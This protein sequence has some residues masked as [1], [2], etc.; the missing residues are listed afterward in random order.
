MK[1]MREKWHLTH[2]GKTVGASAGIF[3]QDHGGHR[4]QH[5]IFHILK[6]DSVQK[7]VLRKYSSEMKRNREHS[8]MEE[9]S[10]FF[11]SRLT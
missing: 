1:T 11:D 6:K 5:N 9:D 4:K 7:S 2:Q 10:A 8:Q 3:C